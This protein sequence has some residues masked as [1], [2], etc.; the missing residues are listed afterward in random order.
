[1]SVKKRLVLTFDA[2]GTLFRPRD[3]IGKAYAEVAKK[4]GLAGLIPC[5]LNENFKNGITRRSKD[6]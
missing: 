1:M 6:L 2:F 4:H 3:S 5:H